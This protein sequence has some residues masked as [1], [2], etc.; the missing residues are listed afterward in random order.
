MESPPIHSQRTGPTRV[1]Q[2]GEHT[3][4]DTQTRDHVQFSS[5]EYQTGEY[6]VHTEG[7][8]PHS[9][10]RDTAASQRVDGATQTE[11]ESL[12]PEE[13]SN[14]VVPMVR[15]CLLQTVRLPPRQCVL[16]RAS[17]DSQL[18]A[19]LVMF[20][21]S[22]RVEQ[23]WGVLAEDSL[24]RPHE[25]GAIQ[26]ALTNPTRTTQIMDA[27]ETLGQVTEASVIWAD[28]AGLSEVRMVSARKHSEQALAWERHRQEKLKEAIGELDLPSEEKKTLQSFLTRH[29]RA[30]CLEEGE[31]GETDLIRMEID[32]G[33]AHPRKQRVRRLPF[34]L[35]QVVTQQLRDMQEHGV[36][37]PSKSP[38]ASPVVLVKKRDGTHRFCVDY[39][40]LN[41]VTKP[42]SF[43]LPRMRTYLMY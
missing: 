29:H 39:R 4:G 21:P 42:D 9:D 38:W 22:E 41:A 24:V 3:N 15:V 18:S 35:R 31:R 19:D 13:E 25:D 12:E 37:Q 7:L 33:D 40:G 26:V 23:V 30:F 27:G 11:V 1:G 17:T 32:T 28:E 14:A 16:A 43:P 34:A 6:E 10:E 5:G 2:A 20:E 8:T 36:I